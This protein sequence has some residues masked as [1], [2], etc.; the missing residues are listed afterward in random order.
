MAIPFSQRIHMPEDVFMRELDDESV[1]LHLGREIYFGLDDIGTRIWTALVSADSIQ[2]AY[3]V[4]LSE[5]DVE[6]DVLRRDLEE[7]L[8][9]LVD[10]ELLRVDGQETA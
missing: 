3:E 9:L 1:I 10:Q 8:T 4:L 5:F 2:A 7:F 6:P